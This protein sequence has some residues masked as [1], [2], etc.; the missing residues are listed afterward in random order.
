[1]QHSRKRH[2]AQHKT[3]ENTNP[4]TQTHIRIDRIFNKI[5]NRITAVSSPKILTPVD[6][7]IGRNM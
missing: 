2:A 4:P 5:N 1:V 3:R 7:H 6:D